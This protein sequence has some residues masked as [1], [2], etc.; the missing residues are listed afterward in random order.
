MSTRRLSVV[1][2]I[3]LLLGV[4]SG[5]GCNNPAPTEAKPENSAKSNVGTPIP[6]DNSRTA[7][8]YIRLGLGA[9][10]R[11]WA[12][13]DM[14]VAARVLTSLTKDGYQQLPRYQSERS[15]EVFARITSA[16]N[17]SVLK[18]R[19]LPLESRAQLMSSYSEGLSAI[20][21]IYM[22]AFAKGEIGDP[23]IVELMGA[24]LRLMV[25]MSDIANELLL[26][27]N[28]SDPTYPIRLG[29]FEKIKRSF[30]SGLAGLFVFI[31]APDGLRPTDLNRLIGYM[32]ETLPKIV[33]QLPPGSQSEAIIQLEKLKANPAV[34]E[35]GPQLEN[36]LAEVKESLEKQKLSK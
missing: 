19:T 10:E 15:G 34:K 35:F 16:Q 12:G 32:Q 9:P 2:A 18:N 8:E 21:K 3:A 22:A 27:L 25:T 7:N 23:E 13:S 31:N 28:K 5:S 36:L 17:L 33:P 6:R 30:A 20:Y 11:E 29:G 24:S 26:T 14:V 4:F 1:N